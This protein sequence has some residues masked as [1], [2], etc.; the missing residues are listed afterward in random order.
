MKYANISSYVIEVI[1]N[2]RRLEPTSVKPIQLVKSV[3]H[4]FPY[5]VNIFLDF[6][7]FRKFIL[8]GGH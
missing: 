8:T 3:I 2:A 5:I 1:Y 7:S 6:L 4:S